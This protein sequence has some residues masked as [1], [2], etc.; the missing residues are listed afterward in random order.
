M[1][2]KLLM[3]ADPHSAHTIKW[4]KYLC[5]KGINIFLFGLKEFNENDYFGIDNLTIKSF[6]MKG[7]I[8]GKQDG[9]FSKLNYIKALPSIRRIIKEF[10][11]N[12][13]HAHYASSYGLLGAL[14]GFHPYIISVYGSDV[15]NFPKKN[16]AT[17]NLLKHNLSKADR[18]LSTSKVMAKEI[19][20]YTNKE[21]VITPFGI[22]IELFKP[23]KV[24]SIFKNGEIV[25]GTIKSL[26]KKYG[27]E[28]LI[29]AFKQLK[30]KLN[31]PKLKLL[32]VGSGKLEEQ[33]RKIVD[34]Y[35]LTDS[36]VFTGY[37]SPI[38]IP[39]YHNMLDIFV[40]LSIEESESFGVAVLESSACEKPV[41]VSNIGGLPEVV[42]NNTTGFLV[43][44]ENI[45]E[46][47]SILERLILNEYLRKELGQ[48]GREFV[49]KS[50][51]WK[52]NVDKMI[53]IYNQ[54]LK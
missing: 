54:L 35:E 40:S 34:E 36:T 25:I 41:V 4:V 13:V 27:I 8:F 47:V 45:E 33:L 39:K 30:E 51:N 31:L 23:L 24:D 32:I 2:L 7:E 26:E 14:S 38:E 53:N 42:I 44:K 28:Y 49:I 22:D 50:Y 15:F 12:I 1:E 37:I 48:N 21:I 43:E 17:K 11:P 16:L 6:Q 18:I 29:K 9:N 5:G 52:N 3:L 19:K 46:T 10:K 20:I